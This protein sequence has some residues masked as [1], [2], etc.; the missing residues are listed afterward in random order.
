MG[1]LLMF[2]S[3]AAITLA[4]RG[5]RLGLTLLVLL[6]VV[7]VG[8]CSI[9]KSGIGKLFWWNLPSYQEYVASQSNPPKPCEGRLF[10]EM[11]DGLCGLANTHY[12]H[13]FRMISGY[14][15]FTPARCLHYESDINALRVAQVQAGRFW[16]ANAARLGLRSGPRG[17]NSWQT[18]ADPLPRVRLLSHVLTSVT[19]ADDLAK[20]LVE[21]TALVSHPIDLPASAPGAA[22]LI[23][24]RPGSISVAVQAPQRQLLL[25]SECYDPGWRVAIDGRPVTLERVNGDFFGCVVDGGRHHVEFAFRPP[26]LLI[27]KIVSLT[28]LLFTCIL[29]L[30]PET[31]AMFRRTA[32]HRLA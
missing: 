10:D 28:A 4:M 12:A 30:G 32:P 18:V 1:P 29:A 14:D 2:G 21:T 26:S 16:P 8:L 17:E 5:R 6:T 3:A 25:L 11:Y 24:D 23:R 9:V 31:A 27:G 7:D 19:P 15:G 20:I 13:G 22:E